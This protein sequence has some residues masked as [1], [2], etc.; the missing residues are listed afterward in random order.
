M[1]MK[2]LLLSGTEETFRLPH[3]GDGAGRRPRPHGRWLRAA[4]YR[5]SGR[6][7]VV[8]LGEAAGDQGGLGICLGSPQDLLDV[9]FCQARAD[10]FGGGYGDWDEIFYDIANEFRRRVIEGRNK[11][12][13]RRKNCYERPL[14]FRT[15]KKD[16]REI[17][18]L[19]PACGSGHFLLYCFALLLVIYEE[20][21]DD[22][23]LGR[24]ASGLPH[25]GR[26]RRA[27]PV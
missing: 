25:E 7:G 23:D 18:I 24:P 15:T 19:D 22:P 3:R 2:D 16:P 1:A 17:K 14:P 10:R 20:A 8:A 21:Y 26:L 4:S 27:C 6:E 11:D 12:D 9:P 5:E 13:L